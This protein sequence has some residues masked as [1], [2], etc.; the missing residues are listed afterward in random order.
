VRMPLFSR[1]RGAVEWL[2]AGLGNPGA[3]YAG[4]RHNLGFQALE[5]LAVRCRCRLRAARGGLAATAEGRL[6]GGRALRLLR[7][8]TFMNRSGEAVAA[9]LEEAKLPGERLIVLVDDLALPLGGLRIRSGG[10]DG[11]HNGLQSIIRQLGDD[12]FIRVRMGIGPSG[13]EPPAAEEWSDY[14]LGRFVPQEEEAARR[15][16]LRGAEAAE[17]IA[18]RGLTA[19]MNEFNRRRPSP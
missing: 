19:A 14:V 7:P 16:A 18:D 8:L 10:G 6:S 12:S 17:A 3:E 13:G 15:A 4:T 9:A 11:G 1:R 2:V 5:V